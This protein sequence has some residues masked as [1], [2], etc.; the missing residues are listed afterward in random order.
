MAEHVLGA[1]SATAYLVA[2]PLILGTVAATAWVWLSPRF[3]LAV[4]I[5]VTT[6]G[7]LL[8]SPHAMFYD[9]GLLAITAIVA[10]DRLGPRAAPVVAVV[11]AGS[12]LQMGAETFR[13]APLFVLVV[14][15]LGILAMQ[16]KSAPTAASAAA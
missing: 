14:A 1:G 7:I 16:A 12:W 13:F 11:W 6:A 3:D 2:A 5:A 15:G 8:M 10:V 9:A 4:R